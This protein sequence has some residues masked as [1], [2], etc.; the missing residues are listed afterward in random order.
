MWTRDVGYDRRK[1]DRASNFQFLCERRSQS[2]TQ[3]S[4]ILCYSAAHHNVHTGI[5]SI[6]Y[7]TLKEEALY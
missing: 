6:R 1:F 2:H 7:R 3:K 4:H 5:A